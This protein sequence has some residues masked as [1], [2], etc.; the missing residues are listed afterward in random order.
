MVLNW[1]P[2]AVYPACSGLISAVPVLAPAGTARP[3][4]AATASAVISATSALPAV[5]ISSMVPRRDTRCAG[6][7]S[8]GRIDQRGAVQRG[9]GRASGHVAR[10][11]A[12]HQQGKRWRVRYL[13]PAGKERSRSFDRKPDA[14]R[15]LNA[16]AAKVQD[17]TWQDPSLGKLTLRRYAEQT[18]LP[19]LTTEASSQETLTLRLR[20]HILPVLGDK[21]LGQLAAEPSIIKAWMAGLQSGVAPGYVRTIFTSLS[22]VLQAAVVDGKI[23]RNPCSLVKA[24]RAESSR[25]EPWPAAWV[26]GAR[27]ALPGRYQALADVGAGLGMRQGEVFGLAVDD[28]DFLRR[29]VHVRRQVKIVGARL[30]FGPPKGGKERDIPLPDSVALRLSAHIAEYP[31]VSVTLPWKAPAGKPVTARLLFTS[32]QRAALNRNYFNTYI[33]KPSL[34]AAGVPATR[35]NGFHALRHYFASA[36]LHD[37]VDVRALATYLGHG[38]P[39]FTLRVYTHLMPDAADRMRSA[40]DHVMSDGPV[41]GQAAQR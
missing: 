26:S 29:V 19:A 23:T 3:S 39:G 24:P 8:R 27:D 12:W 31:P 32:R 25:V 7:R 10:W 33:W 9:A 17:G 28:V 6:E 22:G 36:L 16:T 35:D 34:L 38:D 20:L 13:D 1:P 21:T 11:P 37:G 5:S 41:V 40:V 15:F 2:V 18:Y 14:Q 4:A 30:A